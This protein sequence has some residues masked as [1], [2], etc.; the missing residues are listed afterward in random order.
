MG[1][2]GKEAKAQGRCLWCGTVVLYTDE[3]LCCTRSDAA[4]ATPFANVRADAAAD[5]G[6][7]SESCLYSEVGDS[8]DSMDEAAGVAEDD[9]VAASGRVQ[10]Q[11]SQYTRPL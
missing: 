3:V 9:A 11:T 8:H 7:A 5:H 6:A 2:R 10:R 1:Q 4:I